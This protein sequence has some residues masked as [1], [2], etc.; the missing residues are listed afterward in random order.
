MGEIEKDRQEERPGFEGDRKKDR[1][2]KKRE[3]GIGE[4]ERQREVEKKT[5]GVTERER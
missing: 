5:E 3:T 2:G 1:G 4:K